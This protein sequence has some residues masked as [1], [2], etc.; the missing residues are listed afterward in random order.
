MTE[1]KRKILRAQAIYE[2]SSIK[3]KAYALCD[4]S[5][6]NRVTTWNIAAD[7]YFHVANETC[8]VKLKEVTDCGAECI[9]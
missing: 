8:I 6:S 4:Q 9:I 5:Y 3:R 7:K 2:R 1:Y